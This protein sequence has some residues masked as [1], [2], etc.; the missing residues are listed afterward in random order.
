MKKNFKKFQNCNY[1]EKLIS[2]G[3]KIVIGISG[4]PDSVALALLLKKLSEKIKLDL[5]LVHI[6]YGLRGE[7]SRK[8]EEFVKNL[9][10]KNNLELIIEKYKNKC[11]KGNLEENLRNFRYNFFEKI[12]KEKDFNC[13]AVGHTKDDQIE[14]FLMNMIR[15][16][17]LD[18]LTALK[19]ING[20]IIRPVIFFEK[21]ELI[22][23]LKKEGQSYRIDK[24]NYDENFMR[25]K[26]RQKLIPLLEKKYNPQIKKNLSVLI[27]HLFNVKKFLDEITEFFY[28]KEVNIIGGVY[29]LETQ[30][31]SAM[32]RVLLKNIF[33]KV[34]L[35]LRGDL[36]NISN[37]NFNEFEKI[38]YSQKNKHQR[39]KINNLDIIRKGNKV[40]I[41]K[42]KQ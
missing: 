9:A 5:I 34:I 12:R 23:F 41:T 25:N 16:S 29:K 8:D 15:G 13:I 2:E 3:N 7:D 39:M 42:N 26:V 28:D 19:C 37:A 17:G 38:I 11:R 4:G 14:S 27:S 32:P 10:E 33:R 20:K 40:C 30:S 6:N 22:E 36:K 18:G 21:A 1:R 31:C 24:S 35:E